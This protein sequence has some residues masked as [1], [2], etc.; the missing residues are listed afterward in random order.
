MDYD[1]SRATASRLIARFG[2][3]GE[4]IFSRTVRTAWDPLLGTETITTVNTSVLVVVPPDTDRSRELA[5]VQGW[6]AQFYVPAV[7]FTP[8]PGDLVTLPGRTGALIVIAPVETMAPDGVAIMHT[9][10]ARRG[11]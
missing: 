3:D 1:R 2:N 9:V 10:M 8:Q 4:A 6:D 5:R 7:A 11:E